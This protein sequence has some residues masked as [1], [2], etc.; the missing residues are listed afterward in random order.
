MPTQNLTVYFIEKVPED[1]FQGLG[2]VKI[3]YNIAQ[4]LQIPI[5][6]TE[7][8][9]IP[10]LEP[11]CCPIQPEDKLPW[12]KP[13]YQSHYYI[14]PPVIKGKSKKFILH[15]KGENVVLYAQYSLTIDAIL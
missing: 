8:I 6:Y 15:I 2:W 14:Y 5:K 4:R 13:T 11:Y 9:A 1:I 3:D 7:I 12:F 10:N